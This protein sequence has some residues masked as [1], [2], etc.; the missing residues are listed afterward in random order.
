MRPPVNAS[1]EPFAPGDVIN[2]L[3]RVITARKHEE[4]FATMPERELKALSEVIAAN[5][6]RMQSSKPPLSAMELS[7]LYGNIQVILLPHVKMFSLMQNRI[8]FS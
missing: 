6:M 7:I 1:V 2:K 3:L 5:M 4:L 8:Y